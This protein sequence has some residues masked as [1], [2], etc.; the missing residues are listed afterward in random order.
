MLAQSYLIFA[1]A[2]PTDIAAAAAT[3]RQS[4]PLVWAF[5]FS[6]HNSTLH[7]RGGVYYFQTTVGD[8]L[9]MLDMGM[10]AWNYN[11][12]FR[13]TLAPVGVARTWF[14]NHPSETKLYLNITELVKASPTP[15]N[16]IAELKK[17]GFKVRKAMGEIEQ[18]HFTTFLQELRKLSYPLVT[19]P[20][21]GDRKVDAEILTFEIRDT[22]S[23]EAEMA[24]QMVGIDRDKTVLNRATESIKLVK[25]KKD[26]GVPA[27]TGADAHR[28][29]LT[30]FTS[31]LDEAREL[32]ADE[33]GCTVL[34]KGQHR[35]L[36]KA[37]GKEFM[38]V[39]IDEH[40]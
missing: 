31:D 17:L 3:Q 35:L 6:G 40:K 34:R 28:K 5:A 37:H 30:L 18:K 22:G 9:A 32:L 1:P 14:A 13:D 16:D 25:G 36:L 20:I 8:A 24:L 38:L 4:I 7:T 11:S 10:A 27:L 23:V 12:Y 2:G 26:A 15:D 39:K 29:V 33:L 21:T 19:V